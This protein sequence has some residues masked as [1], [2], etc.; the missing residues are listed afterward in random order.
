MGAGVNQEAFLE[1][2]WDEVIDAVEACVPP[3]GASRVDA[4]QVARMA[5]YEALFSWCA[6]F[7]EAGHRVA[8]WLA[9]PPGHRCWQK[10]GGWTPEN[11]SYVSRA[12]PTA[13]FADAEAARTRLLAKKVS[14]T[15]LAAFMNAQ[16]G[17]ALAGL[18]RILAEQ[19]WRAGE[20]CGVHESLLSADPSGL[21][22][23][24]GSWPRRA[25]SRKQASP[26][27]PAPRC[28]VKKAHVLVFSPDGAEVVAA[29]GGAVTAIESG[30]ARVRCAFLANTSHVAWSPDGA[31]IAG[32]STSGEIAICRADTGARA[33][34]LAQSSEGAAPCFTSGGHLVSGTWSGEV[35]LWDVA[36]GK[37]VR[38]LEVP[39]AMILRM[40][41]AP[42]G[43]V[44]V[45]AHH[46]KGP[47]E[48][49]FF[50]ATLR[51]HLGN[52]ALPQGTHDVTVCPVTGRALV[53]GPHSAG[54]LGRGA[55]SQRFKTDD[56]IHS[57]A[58]SPDG[59]W[60]VLTLMRGGFRVGPANDLS[61]GGE[62]ALAY[63]NDAA[64]SPDG[65]RVALSTWEGGEV[66]AL[67]ALARATA[68]A[69]I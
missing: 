35:T 56:V 65:S 6:A 68:P 30:K 23:G 9:R 15:A 64:F 69:V 11:V 45:L 50:D 40:A 25:R 20:L 28:T 21:C 34:V 44:A 18:R 13:P 16:H 43:N 2:L 27:G 59:R 38:R 31:W 62:R 8:W 47:V 4:R 67:E 26:R 3:K 5:R 14:A 60:V 22:A 46:A 49:I 36:R 39:D 41:L 24:P 52:V 55:P 29:K 19:A 1:R 51:S 37:P 12:R 32:V 58:I 7:D 48:L 54:W 42:N 61:Q 33:R 10:L 17:E 66:W 53:T 57:G 63:A